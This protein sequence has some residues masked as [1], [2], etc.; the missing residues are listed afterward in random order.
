MKEKSYTELMKIE[1]M[2]RNQDKE[3][4]IQYLYIDMLLTE[5]Q[6]TAEKEKLTKEIDRAIDQRN[7][8]AFLQLSKKFQELNKRFGT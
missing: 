5:I 4:F 7:R 8:P 2:N 6:L 1:A 3:Q